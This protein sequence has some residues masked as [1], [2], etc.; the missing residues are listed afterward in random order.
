MNYQDR[1]K[2]LETDDII[3]RSKIVANKINNLIEKQKN[4]SVMEYG[5]GTGLIG[6][7]LCSECNKMVLI[8]SNEEMINII[9]EKIKLFKINNV[10]PIQ[11]D[12]TKEPYKKEKFDLIFIS[13]TLHHIIDIEDIIKKFYNLLNDNGSL[14]IID[15]DKEDGSFHS[16]QVDFKGHNGFEHEEIKNVLNKTGFS[17]IQI[18]TFLYDEKKYKEKTIP[19]SLF[20]AIAQK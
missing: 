4:I 5:C 11:L 16:N 2:E 10:T 1:I 19:Y 9:K 15:L 3:K 20:C 12:L 13:L 6:F 7:D 8:D 17:N 14:C 18:E